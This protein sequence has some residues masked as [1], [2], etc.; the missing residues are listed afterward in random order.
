MEEKNKKLYSTMLLLVGALFIVISGGIFVSTTWNYIPEVVK[1]L[2]LLVI[3]GAF[4]CGSDYA[5]RKQGL[6]KTGM[7]LYYLGVCFAGFTTIAFLGYLFD[8]MALLLLMAMAVMSVPVILHFMKE[9]DLLDVIFQVLLADGMVCCAYTYSVDTEPLAITLIV[10][11]VT[12]LLAGFVYYCKKELP[13]QQGMRYFSLGAYIFHAIFS[14]PLVLIALFLGE[15]F[16]YTLFPMAMITASAVLLHKAYENTVTRVLESICFAGL[17]FS[18]SAFFV[19]IFLG[20]TVYDEFELICFISFLMDLALMVYLKRTEMTIINAV[21]VSLAEMG[22][23][24]DYREIGLFEIHESYY[25]YAFFMAIAVLALVLLDKARREDKKSYLLPGTWFV[26]GVNTLLAFALTMYSNY[27]GMSF[28]I[29]LLCLQLGILCTKNELAAAFLK[30]VSVICFI[31]PM[32]D[33][34]IFPIVFHSAQTGKVVADF[35]AEYTT[36]LFALGIVLLGYIWYHISEKIRTFQF[37]GVCIL[38]ALLI[39]NNLVCKELPN[40]L[41]LGITALVMLVAATILKQKNYAIAAAITLVLIVLYLTK[42]VWMSIAWW[43]YLFVAG[44]GLVIYAI[45]KEKAE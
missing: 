32:V 31:G 24:D 37:F 7:G 40:I 22:Q 26:M 43:V 15:S 29:A 41:F 5:E 4:F 12:M 1:K 21:I 28:L 45:K 33:E 11:A 23:I 27:Y 10:A 35:T 8:E 44:V 17:S 6:T 9:K 14:A 20:T 19:N 13:E 25:P 3:T 30:T 39:G 38:L 18:V 16:L 2:C 34:A 36:F 42:E